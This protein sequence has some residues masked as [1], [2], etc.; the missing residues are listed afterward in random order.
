M[1]LNA[2]VFDYTGISEKDGAVPDDEVFLET[3]FR[4]SGEG[5]PDQRMGQIGQPFFTTKRDKVGLG[6]AITRQI[7]SRHSGR[8]EIGSEETKGTSVKI[9]L[10]Y[11]RNK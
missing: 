8:I 6:L 4:D 2:V 7:I 11:G 5:I 1:V 10:P 9:V 3:E